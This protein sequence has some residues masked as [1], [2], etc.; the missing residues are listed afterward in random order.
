MNPHPCGGTLCHPD[1]A[2]EKGPGWREVIIRLGRGN[3]AREPKHDT[4]ISSIVFIECRVTCCIS[5]V[6]FNI[7][8]MNIPGVTEDTAL[9]EEFRSFKCI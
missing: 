5:S 9:C 8:E 4:N 6:V 2:V 3:A 7:Q 1:V